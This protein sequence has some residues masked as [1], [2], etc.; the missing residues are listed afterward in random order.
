M[1]IASSRSQRPTS[2]DGIVA[3]HEALNNAAKTTNNEFVALSMRINT[4]TAVQQLRSLDHYASLPMRNI[5]ISELKHHLVNG[6]NTERI[7]DMTARSLTD[8]ALPIGLQWA[9]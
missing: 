1:L 4:T 9:F 8:D 3:Q 5:E 2:L 7:L 6:W